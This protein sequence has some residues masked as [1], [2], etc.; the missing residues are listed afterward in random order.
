MS[1]LIICLSLA[2]SVFAQYNPIGVPKITNFTSKDYGYESQNFD[3]SQGKD[4]LI[5]FGNTNG[6]IE[7][8]NHSWD[9]IRM[10]GTPSID[11]D[12]YDK[13]FVGGFNTIGCLNKTRFGTKLVSLQ[14][15]KS[16]KPGQI[17]KIVALC[18]EV[19]FASDTCIYKYQ[20]DA[21]SVFLSPE[22][23][24]EIFKVAGELYVHV[25][26]T[27]LY[28]YENG[29]LVL[30]DGMS[31]FK[32]FGYHDITIFDG[33]LVFKPR[34]SLGLFVRTKNGSKRFKTQIDKMLQEA[35]V[36]RL[37]NYRNQF[38]LI[39]TKVNG[40]F[41]IDKQGKLIFH[42]NKS[43]GLAD[44]H[45]SNILIDKEQQ[46]WVSTFN[47]IS[48]IDF[49]SPFTY[50]TS[51]QRLNVSIL[52]LVKH[53]EQMYLS[54]NQGVYYK[55]KQKKRSVNFNYND[56]LS[57]FEKVENL[58]LRVKKLVN[59][60]DYLYACTDYGLFIVRDYKAELLIEGDFEDIVESK[61]HKG[62][63]YISSSNGLLIA[64]QDINGGLKKTG[65]LANLDYNIRTIAE[66]KEGNVWLGSNNDGLF[67][68]DF[69][70]QG[71]LNS[72]FVHIQRGHGLPANYDW[73]DVYQTQ[74]GIL[75]STYNGIYRYNENSLFVKDSL[76]G[77]NFSENNRWVYPI[78][79]DVKGRLWFSS[80][81]KETYRKQSGVA[82]LI[83]QKNKYQVSFS[84]FQLIS[85]RTIE[86]VY[87]EE[88]QGVTWFGSINGLIRF[89]DDYILKDTSS[90][91]CMLRHVSIEGDTVLFD[92]SV[93]TNKCKLLNSPVVFTHQQNNIRFEFT[94]PF[95]QSGNNLTY[96]TKLEGFQDQWTEWSSEYY[97]EYTNL[98][99]DNYV[100]KVRAR[101]PFGQVSEIT[102][103]EFIV[104]P[105]LY[106][107]WWAFV[108]YVAFG[109]SLFFLLNK[110]KEYRH[111]KE[112]YELES[113]IASRTEELLKQKEQTERLVNRILPKRT[114]EEFRTKGKASSIRYEMATV[115]FSDIQGFTKIAEETRPEILIKQLDIIF[116]SFDQIIEKYDI[117][118][119]KT[120]GDAYMCAG[121]IPTNNSTNPIEVV[122]A[123][124][125]MQAIVSQINKEESVDFKVRIGVHTGPLVAGVIGTQRIAY[126]IWGDTV[127]M[128]S[129]METHGEVT[130]VNISSS[131]YSHVKDFFH[132]MY[133]GKTPVKYKGDLDMYYIK[134]IRP[135]LAKG[136]ASILPN[137]DFIAKLQMVRLQDLQNDI[138]D[139]LEKNLPKNLYYHNLKH[140]VN[141][142]YQTETIAR[143][144][145][146]TER[147]M[148]ILKTAALFHDIGFL[149]SYDYHEERGTEIAQKTLQGYH[150]SQNQITQI[151]ELILA[152]KT[153]QKP[154]N[155]L[156]EIIC[157]ADLDYLGRPDFIPT[158]QNLFRELFERNKIGT[159]EQWNRMQMKF[160]EKHRYFT[161]SARKL[162]EPEK[163]KRLAELKKML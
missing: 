135:E 25:M 79:E 116:K 101:S 9:I 147:Q 2:K 62:Q 88:K 122:L 129:R 31:Q 50:F 121:G 143:F 51:D 34:R 108:F 11:V 64:T 83:N 53:N 17:N 114:V 158:S 24:V 137:E 73:I 69:T 44:N 95:Y 41:I 26:E 120:I 160:M 56:F 94:A 162:R 163:Q 107:A 93:Y 132:C 115:L 21:L 109:S 126:D 138:L 118:K 32:D 7:Y 157:D 38:L 80:G 63:I 54:T 105:P 14:N 33:N 146:V 59:L 131:T 10:S 117:E 110:R 1:I 100:F 70:K 145:G 141:V 125:E 161:A 155:L 133:R 81:L 151:C 153:P 139:K 66:D 75:F 67:R 148:L 27:G 39:G 76:L 37:K 49:S 111:T 58:N 124:L 134:S 68:V 82:K 72:E 123:A 20:N 55:L 113:I 144:E 86:S 96:Q 140:T 65:Y 87:R 42:L 104:K 61:A 29:E 23:S 112:K 52:S 103:F 28:R 13:V 84:P 149:V 77:I 74:T 45:I 30:I 3:I 43:S 106:L 78:H 36:S 89:Q 152:T 99:S 35:N 91:P 4:G 92:K 119:I 154:Q 15:Q 90:V 142:F 5:Y 156:Q 159:I 16:N 130:Q 150:Y 57:L 127:N 8:D 19:F 136:R 22:K 40:I 47:G 46:I 85:D 71:E 6:V 102:S 12:C 128:A 60:N 48:Y 18:G 98:R 97:K